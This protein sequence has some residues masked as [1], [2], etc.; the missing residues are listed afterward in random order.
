L[1]V[2]TTL[3]T[4]VTTEVDMLITVDPSLVRVAVAVAVVG[5]GVMTTTGVVEADV[6]KVDVVE[7]IMY[8][9]TTPQSNSEK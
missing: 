2:A 4:A 1:L 7:T 6:V 9:E 8:V 3:V 5:L